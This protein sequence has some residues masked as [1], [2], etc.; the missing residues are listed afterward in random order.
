MK[1]NQLA[2]VADERL[3]VRIERIERVA[4]DFFGAR[5]IAFEVEVLDLPR[6]ILEYKEPELVESGGASRRRPPQVGPPELAARQQAADAPPGG[7][8]HARRVNQTRG[9]DLCGCQAARLVGPFAFQDARIE[10][11]AFRIGNQSV[12][13][14]I[15]GIA[16]AACGNVCRARLRAAR[17][18]GGW[19]ARRRRGADS[20]R[21]TR[22]GIPVGRPSDW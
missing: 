9:F 1:L 4:I 10:P 18:A 17:M 2:A 3:Q 21:R 11:A 16:G 20:R 7:C 6:R 14:P 8:I 15:G 12:L 13:Q 22:G 19:R 5:G